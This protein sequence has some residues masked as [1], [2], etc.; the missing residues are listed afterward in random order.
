MPMPRLPF[1]CSLS[2]STLF[3]TIRLLKHRMN[4][5]SHRQW[6]CSLI[7]M[8]CFRRAFCNSSPDNA[9]EPIAQSRRQG[10]S[11]TENSVSL[12]TRQRLPAATGDAHCK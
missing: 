5:S 9:V 6:A 8:R 2:T 7:S 3:F 4:I 11:E 1:T 10:R 12:L